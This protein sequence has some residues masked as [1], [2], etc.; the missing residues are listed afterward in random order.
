M[1]RKATRPGDPTAL[2]ALLWASDQPSGRGATSV[3][4]ITDA[5]LAIADES[6]LDA[7]T[8]RS[9]AD[10][11]GVGAMTLYG[12]VPGRAE[13]VELMVDRLAAQTYAGQR[14]PA[15]VGD[16]REAAR[17][18]ARR[19]YEHALAHPW[20]V[21]VTPARPVL[22]PGVLVKYDQELAALDGIGLSD[23]AMDRLLSSITNLAAGAARWQIGMQ[24]T[25]AAS[26]L[27]DEQWWE[28]MGP[29][30]AEAMGDLRV[31][32]ADRVGSA[33]ANA[34][35]PTGSLT[36]ALEALLDGVAQQLPR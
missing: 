3:P 25:R 26:G 30:L 32:V 33:A 8:M 21:D 2:L 9:V 34:G 13:L 10:R 28:R 1:P 16:W 27:T 29:A 31:P 22:G 36:F 35:D 18:I 4:A 23:V 17:H 11:L 7:V 6:G 19:T 5:A 15:D 24:R 14:A 20:S 12:Y